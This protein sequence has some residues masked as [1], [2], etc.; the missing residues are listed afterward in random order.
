MLVMQR[1][2]VRKTERVLADGAYIRGDA[3]RQLLLWWAERGVKG[4]WVVPIF[5]ACFVTCHSVWRLESTWHTKSVRDFHVSFINSFLSLCCVVH[6]LNLYLL[7]PF[8][9]L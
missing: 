2:R 4:C 1:E 6:G 5:S 3:A 9:Y 7:G 8:V